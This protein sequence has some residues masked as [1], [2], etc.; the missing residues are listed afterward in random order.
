MRIVF[1]GTPDFGIPSLRRLVR[2]GYDVAA[3]V[4]QPDRPAGRGK[5]LQACPL[6]VAAQLLGLP[7]LSFERIRAKENVE[8]LEALRPDVMVT[9]AY[10]QILNNRVLGIAPMGVVNVHGSLLPQYRGPAPIQW[11][12]I[13]GEQK[14]GITT[15]LTE[16]GVDSGPILLQR[17]LDIRKEDT[18][19]TLFARLAD[20]GADL[21][22]DTLRG[23]A[24]GALTPQPQDEEQATYFPM[25]DKAAGRLC[26]TKSAE[27]LDCQIRGVT[28][29]P[30]AWTMLDGEVLK[31]GAAQPLPGTGQPGQVMVS[32]PKEGLVV[33]TGQGRLRLITAQLPGKKAMPAEDLLRG[34]PIPVGTQLGEE[35]A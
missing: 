33:G 22:L 35:E 34:H 15:M 13:Q 25:L 31:I 16:R 29:W 21:L 17:E 2:E 14:T 26:W 1:L 9:A 11:A 24:Q 10:G 7:V 27:A 4:T 20:L 5:K 28:P 30:G 32:S 8:Q 6:K 12:L 23:L 3:V 18:A 19:Q